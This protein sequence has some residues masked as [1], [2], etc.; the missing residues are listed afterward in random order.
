MRHTK[1]AQPPGKPG[2]NLLPRRCKR[3][4]A[5]DALHHLAA[6]GIL[7]GIHSRQSRSVQILR[8]NYNN[9]D[10]QQSKE[11]Q[12]PL[13]KVSPAHCFESA[14]ERDYQ[15]GEGKNDHCRLRV[16]FR[17]YRC[18]NRSPCNIG[19]C[20]INGK[21]DEKNNR[22]DYLQR[23]AFSQKTVSQILGNR[24]GI[25]GC[26]GKLSQPLGNTN[27]VGSSTQCQ[28]DADPHLTEAERKN[29]SRKPHQ[30]PGRHIGGLRR[31]GC[32]PW[33]HLSSA[34]EEICLCFFFALFK[35]KVNTYADN[36]SEV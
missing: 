23:M 13:E 35:E 15:H 8:N 24:N 25:P 4:G 14:E 3:T 33:T 34:Q 31:H 2:N 5:K 10:S 30:Q 11:H 36:C 32:D 16:Q 9:R 17:K 20:H 18:K 29:T 21:A 27:P 1:V 28:T 26:M 22:T 19:R 7:I 6:Y 12:K